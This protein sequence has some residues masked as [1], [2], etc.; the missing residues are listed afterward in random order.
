MK[1]FNSIGRQIQEISPLTPEQI[2]IYTCGPTVYDHVT[3]GNFRTYIFDDTLRRTLK[4][5]G[6]K[7]KHVMNI[8]D[9]DDKTIARSRQDFPSESPEQALKQLTAKYE[10]IFFDDAEKLGIDYSDST[11]TRATGNIPQMQELIIKIA[12]AGLAYRTDDGIYFDTLK[13]HNQVHKYGVLTETALQGLES[14]S[15]RTGSDEYDKHEAIDFALWKAAK[16]DEPS[17]PFEFQGHD[18]AGRPG[19]HIECSAMSQRCLGVPFDIHTGGVDLIFPHHENEIAQTRAGENVQLAQIFVHGEHLLVDGQRMGKSLN[20]FYTVEDIKKK[21][22]DP[23][24]FRLL[25]LQAHYRTQLN[26]TWESLEAAQRTLKNFYA[27]ADLK[28]QNFEAPDLKVNFEQTFARILDS[29]KND[30]ATPEALGL[31]NGLINH[32]YEHGIDSEAIGLYAQKAD[33]LFGL[34]LSDRQ[35]ISDSQKKTIAER[36]AARQKADWTASDELR[37]K[38]LSEGIEISDTGQGPVWRR[39]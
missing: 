1:I 12:T 13:Y 27:W 6:F 34:G 10:K 31:F 30:L 22:I 14:Q 39:V 28:F 15:Q 38:L 26:F 36:E 11:I 7:V 4:A 17:W 5:A 37:D 16:Q 9:I 21:G 3:I 8:T 20:N 35:D 2:G 19:W 33:E 32:S 18:V 23:L 24:A 29:L 25:V